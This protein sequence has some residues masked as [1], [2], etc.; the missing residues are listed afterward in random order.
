MCTSPRYCDSNHPGGHGSS[1]SSELGPRRALPEKELAILGPGNSKRPLRDIYLL[2]SRAA[3]AG[4]VAGF[5]SSQSHAWFVQLSLPIREHKWWIFAGV[6]G[7]SNAKIERFNSKTRLTNRWHRHHSPAT[8]IAIV[9]TQPRRDQAPR[10][11]RKVRRTQEFQPM[12]SRAHRYL[13]PSPP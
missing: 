10:Y 9:Q 2:W 1:L 7:Q 8:M 6:E 11:G 13:M 5:V 12:T 4:P 3:I